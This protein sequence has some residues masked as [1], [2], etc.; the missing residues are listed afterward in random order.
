MKAM[1]PDMEEVVFGK[2]LVE[3]DRQTG[4]IRRV[5]APFA[6]GRSRDEDEFWFGRLGVRNRQISAVLLVDAV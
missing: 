1:C 6:Q 2:E 4:Q 3:L 5:R